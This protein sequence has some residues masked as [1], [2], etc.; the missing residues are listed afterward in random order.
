MGEI[1]GSVILEGGLKRKR[2]K[3]VLFDSGSTLGHL[4]ESIAKELGFFISPIEYDMDI[5]DGTTTKINPALGFM[6]VNGCRRPVV[7]GVSKKGASPVIVGL[8]QMQLM[9]IKLDPEKE[10]YTVRC[11]V[12]KA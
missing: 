2:I 6:S 5:A 3:N 11:P 1:R 7:I 12:P 8:S 4:D 9:G 10:T